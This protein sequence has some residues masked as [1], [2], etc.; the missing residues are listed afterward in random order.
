MAESTPPQ[1]PDASVGHLSVHLEGQHPRDVQFLFERPQKRLYGAA[2]VSILIHGG[3]VLAVVL[4][5]TYT[6]ASQEAKDAF[7]NKIKDI[8]WI[9]Q[10]GPGGGGGG[11]GN[12][13]K[14]PPKLMTALPK[15]VMTPPPPEVP[16]PVLVPI[17]NPKLPD[18][19]C[20]PRH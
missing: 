2:G 15:T 19:C 17:D 16:K 14:A 13:M 5:L 12:R 1:R 4:T 8:I 11:G 6:A 18:W 10:P 7:H 20:P 3:L 9:A